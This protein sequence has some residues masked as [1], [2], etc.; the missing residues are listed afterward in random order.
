[1]KETKIDRID[2]CLNDFN[3]TASCY[4]GHNSIDLLSAFIVNKINE[5]DERSPEWRIFRSNICIE[6]TSSL[7][8]GSEDHLI[9]E[10]QRYCTYDESKINRKID[11]D[12][13]KKDLDMLK[14]LLGKYEEEAKEMMYESKNH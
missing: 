7:K 11:E 1:M 10:Y 8:Y 6:T 2:I 3:M 13:K 12:N 14:E 9:L 4:H 5:L